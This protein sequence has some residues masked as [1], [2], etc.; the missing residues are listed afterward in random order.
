M[1]DENISLVEYELVMTKYE[2][3]T[4]RIWI[5]I[6]IGIGMIAGSNIFW[7]LHIFP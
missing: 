3:K 2:R 1:K 4:R 6:L 5:S 7:L